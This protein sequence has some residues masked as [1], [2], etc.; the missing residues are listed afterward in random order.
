MWREIAI[1]EHYQ[2]EYAWLCN[3]DFK[4]YMYYPLNAD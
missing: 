1:L 4:I 3:A 2:I